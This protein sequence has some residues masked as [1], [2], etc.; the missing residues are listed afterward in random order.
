MELLFFTENASIELVWALIVI[1]LAAYANGLL[2]MGF[3]S[4]AMP[5]LV[6]MLSFRSAMI[7]T[8][9]VAFFLSARMTFFGGKTREAVFGFWP[10]PV[11]MVLGGLSGAWLY[12]NLPAHALMWIIL[13]ALAMFLSV[14]YLRSKAP[15]LPERWILPVGAF[16]AFLAGNTEASVNMGAPFLLLFFLL[17]SL[18]P[19]LI[20]QVCNLCF[21][22][23]KVVHIITLSIGG[24]GNPPVL[25]EEW[26][27]GL[28][29][30]PLCLYLCNQGVRVRARV[31]VETYRKWLKGILWIVV[32]VLLNRLLIPGGVNP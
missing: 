25:V 3:V 5:L 16:F 30:V 2:G 8:V 4:V 28:I 11:L 12:Q 14:D 19:Q 31:S 17:T 24:P 9:P 32:L 18:S 27:P 29:L 21:F 22:T 13:A 10:M 7:L 6:F 20:V 26:I 15:Q 1:L 23:G